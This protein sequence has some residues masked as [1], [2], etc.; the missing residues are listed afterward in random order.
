MSDNLF[1]RLYELFQSPG[2]VNW[3]LARE[4]IGSV[5]GDRDVVEPRL[6]EE[7]EE[8]AL[9]AQLHA[10]DT[11]GLTVSSGGGLQP[12]DRATWALENEQSFRFLFE[13]LAERLATMGAGEGPM[14]SI[15]QPLGPALIGLQAG[16]IVG[17]MSH[18]A[19]GQF[20]AGLPALD[21]DRQYLVV[22][23]V[24]AFAAS[25][26]LDPQHVRL[27]AATREVV[28]HAILE[29]PWLRSA[30]VSTVGDY[31]GG[32]ELDPGRLTERLTGLD[33]PSQLEEL[34][35]GE[36]GLPA[37]L[38]GEPDPDAHDAIVA[39]LLFIEGFGEWATRQALAGLVPSIDT[40]ERAHTAHR[41][42]ARQA[43]EV[44]AQLGGIRVDR[45]RVDAAAFTAEVARRW[46]EEAV[47]ALWSDRG[48][49]PTMAELADPVGWAARV[50]L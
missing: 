36:T 48:A 33:D 49:L 27:W 47:T 35:G 32:L 40:I 37:L 11:P 38:G 8:L 19:L 15:M 16:T 42:Q 24:E 18:D 4:V 46:G 20:D 41:D 10:A 17:L 34:L 23:N 12:V 9:A 28:H 5:A 2:P 22:P 50:L 45:S 6:A 3:K 29:V 7:Y 43:D 13:P 14:A 1:D 44:L 39:L 31:F 25:H 26:G 30:V 21:H